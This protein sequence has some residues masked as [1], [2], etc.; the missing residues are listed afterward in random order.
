MSRKIKP[1]VANIAESTTACLITMMQGNFLAFS[2]THWLIASQTGVIA[3]VVASVALLL[4]RTDKRWLIAVVLG[5]VTN[6]SWS[7][8]DSTHRQSGTGKRI[9]GAGCHF[10]SLFRFDPGYS[11]S[12]GA[13][14]RDFWRCFKPVRFDDH[15]IAVQMLQGPL[16]SGTDKQPLP[17]ISG[18]CAHHDGSRIY[19]VR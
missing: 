5:A 9:P 6:A 7:A 12:G 11:G 14:V 16:S 4:A 1:F 18:D 13:I 3:G 19:P 8:L 15:E 17:S 10:A 2:L